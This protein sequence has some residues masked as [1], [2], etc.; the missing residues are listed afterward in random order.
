MRVFFRFWNWDHVAEQ[1][2]IGWTMLEF[3]EELE[4]AH[5][6][7][8]PAVVGG[9]VA[10]GF[11]ENL[12]FVIEGIGGL[13]GFDGVGEGGMLA[14]DFL[15]ELSLSGGPG[16]QLTPIGNGHFLIMSRSGSV[17][18]WKAWKY[19]SSMA[20]KDLRDSPLR[21][22]VAASI[23]CLNCWEA[24]WAHLRRPS[25][26]LG[27]RDLAPFAR[28]AAMR[29]AE[30]ALR[31]GGTIWSCMG[32]APWVWVDDW[33]GPGGEERGGLPLYYYYCGWGARV[34]RR[35]PCKLLVGR[36]L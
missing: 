9:F 3:A 20:V 24:A 35:I 18:G 10:E 34:F 33:R 2:F 27:P 36:G 32:C 16:A 25:G 30:G 29:F 23:L 28:A 22:M 21:R 7:A 1:A 13:A 26:V 4:V 14:A 11:L 17:R 6:A 31:A 5:G 15:V 8:E 12:A 19:C